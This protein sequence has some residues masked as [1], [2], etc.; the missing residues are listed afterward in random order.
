MTGGRGDLFEE[1]AFVP[2]EIAKV[3]GEQNGSSE[4]SCVLGVK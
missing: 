2:M 4:T 3:Q 1:A